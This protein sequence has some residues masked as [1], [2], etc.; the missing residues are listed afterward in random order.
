MKHCTME[1]VLDRL[2]LLEYLVTPLDS[3]TPS[4]SEL[5]GRKFNSLLPDVSN[6]K[7]SDVLVKC[8]DAQL[9][10]DTRG[11]TLPELPVGSQVGLWNHITNKFD[12]GIVSARDARLYTICTENGTHASRNCINI[13]QTDTP[14]ELK[15]MT[16]PVSSFA[17][18][19]HAPPITTVY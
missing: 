8:H 18:S 7:H 14:L 3:N 4:P 10:H 9:Q 2:A 12:V 6:S 1:K 11:R 15:I 19:K 17:K 13:K 5:N 16:Q